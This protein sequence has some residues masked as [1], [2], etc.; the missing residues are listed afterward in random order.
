MG[1][2]AA[3]LHAVYSVYIALLGLLSSLSK[4]RAVKGELSAILRSILLSVLNKRGHLHIQRFS[5][6]QGMLPRLNMPYRTFGSY[7]ST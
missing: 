6:L 2:A 7:R 4:P 1:L 5:C 3:I